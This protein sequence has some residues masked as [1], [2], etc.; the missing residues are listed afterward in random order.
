MPTENPVLAE[1]P[2]Q[3]D[4]YASITDLDK[5]GEPAGATDT[6]REANPEGESSPEPDPEPAQKAAEGKDEDDDS[7]ESGLKRKSGSARLKEQNRQ[8]RAELEAARQFVP[9]PTEEGKFNLDALI[10]KEIGPAPQEKYFTDFLD[11]QAERAAWLGE[12]RQVGREL[13]TRAEQ[14]SAAQAQETQEIFDDF[15][16]RA[17]ETAKRIPDLEQVLRSAKETPKDP[18]VLRMLFTSEK[19]PE[20]AYFLSK[21]QNIVRSLNAMT[22]L[23]AA[24]ELGR[25]ESRL[26]SVS[27][28]TVTKAPNPVEPLRGGANPSAGK[29]PDKMDFDQYIAWRKAGGGT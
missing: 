2:V 24:R 3:A 16:E 19:G 29:D 8:L 28:K 21:N 27:P 17:A 22:P 23:E 25:L 13:R 26:S 9:K 4:P 20:L 6:D 12:K 18:G 14:A 10:E 11:Y 7:A 1:K 5:P 15:K